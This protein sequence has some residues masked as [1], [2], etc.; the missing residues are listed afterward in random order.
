MR[1]GIL[2][3]QG[4]FREHEMLLDTLQTE[5]FQ[6]RQPKDLDRPFDGLILPG[7]ESTVMKKLLH[8]LDL[9]EPLQKM[10]IA[11]LPVFGTCAGLLLLAEEITNNG[12][13]CFHT[14]SIK[15]VR[16]A[17]GRQLGSFAAE[18][19]FDGLGVIPMVFI[20]AP[21]IESVSGHARILASIDGKIV[22]AREGYQL[23]TAF[24]PE[25]TGNGSVHRYFLDMC[26]KRKS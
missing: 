25:L 9:F 11:G 8:D 17:Y 3:V 1:I 26:Q 7:G 15:A 19:A 18:A 13:P 21:Y 2:A 23:V 24:H 16:N 6:I 10:I 14:M 20:R 4:A 5:H 22:A 12:S